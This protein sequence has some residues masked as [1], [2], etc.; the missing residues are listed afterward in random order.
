MICTKCSAE[1]RDDANYCSGCGNPLNAIPLDEKSTGPQ[2][3]ARSRP[4]AIKT[5]Q[6]GSRPLAVAAE[7][8]Q[9]ESEHAAAQ[10]HHLESVRIHRHQESH[11]A[12]ESEKSS[13]KEDANNSTIL[14]ALVLVFLAILGVGAGGIYFNLHDSNTEA[15]SEKLDDLQE[16]IS[17]A[18]QPIAMPVKPKVQPP[19]NHAAASSSLVTDPMV[20]DEQLPPEASAFVSDVNEAAPAGQGVQDP[21]TTVDEE[22]PPVEIQL[23]RLD[24]EINPPVSAADVIEPPRYKA[25]FKRIFGRVVEERTYSNEAMK[26]RALR[27]WARE[28][29]ILEPDGSLNHKYAIKSEFSPIP[30]H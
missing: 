25:S 29:V 8:L 20:F 19:V 21:E 10:A 2:P 27:L 1:N 15:F 5:P 24:N 26:Q 22:A 18:T 16:S 13:L 6:P 12:D 9:F 30:G 11:G 7:D 23:A 14:L 28:Q 4:S 17:D 3:K